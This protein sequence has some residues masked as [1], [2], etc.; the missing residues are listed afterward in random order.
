MILTLMNW[1]LIVSA[2][3]ATAIIAGIV[4]FIIKTARFR[5]DCDVDWCVKIYHGEEKCFGRILRRTG[6]QVQVEYL[7]PDN[8][9]CTRY[10][11][12]RNIY[13]AW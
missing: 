3:G 13:P 9:V 7:D 12:I 10:F 1:F 8:K 6:D 4:F 11:L 2:C 5:R